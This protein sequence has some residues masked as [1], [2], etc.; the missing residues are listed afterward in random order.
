MN[1]I[2]RIEMKNSFIV[3]VFSFVVL[4]SFS[5]SMRAAVAFLVAAGIGGVGCSILDDIDGQCDLDGCTPERE[6]IWKTGD[7]HQPA[8]PDS[9]I[10]I[11][12]GP[13]RMRLQG[14]DGREEGGREDAVIQ[15]AR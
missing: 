11:V 15:L 6:V 3:I 9:T 7:L 12:G 2:E 10:Y 13:S 5:S 8:F 4:Q 1:N 14:K